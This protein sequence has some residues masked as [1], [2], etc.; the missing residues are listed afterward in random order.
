MNL[1]P[2]VQRIQKRKINVGLD[3]FIRVYHILTRKKADIICFLCDSA[4]LILFPLWHEPLVNVKSCSQNV[5][6][7]SWRNSKSISAF[8]LFSVP[9]DYSI[10]RD[11]RSRGRSG[12]HC[13]SAEQQRENAHCDTH[14][15]SIVL[16]WGQTARSLLFEL[17][18]SS[19]AQTNAFVSLAVEAVWFSVSKVSECRSSFQGNLRPV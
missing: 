9:L 12:L 18:H 10:C 15:L 13:S 17:P 19:I 11:V 14:K 7:L 1:Q 4:P 2:R 16:V 5:R 6:V 8:H 3:Y